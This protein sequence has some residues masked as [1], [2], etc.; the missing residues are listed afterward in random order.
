VTLALIEIQERAICRRLRI[1]YVRVD[2]VWL[3]EQAIKELTQ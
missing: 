3:R 2:R 1:A